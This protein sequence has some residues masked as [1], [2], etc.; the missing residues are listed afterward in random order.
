MEAQEGSTELKKEGEHGGR[1]A[2]VI[3][4][5]Q[6]KSEYCSGVDADGEGD[7]RLVD[8]EIAED[9][10]DDRKARVIYL[11]RTGKKRT[12]PAWGTPSEMALLSKKPF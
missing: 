9:V 2:N 10:R 1:E 5:E 4:Y 12:Y 8:A 11:R 6:V 7:T 3:D